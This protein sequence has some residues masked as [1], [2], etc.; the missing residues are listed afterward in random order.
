MSN[1]LET[2]VGEAVAAEVTGDA[3]AAEKVK[4]EISRLV[5]DEIDTHFLRFR[6]R[7]SVP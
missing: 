1:D 6:R 4:G 7:M 5:K 3:K 2:K